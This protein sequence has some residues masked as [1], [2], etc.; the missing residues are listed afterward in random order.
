M[1][2]TSRRCH[3][4]NDCS[5]WF[6]VRFISHEQMYIIGNQLA[7]RIINFRSVGGGGDISSD[8]YFL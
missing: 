2:V 6:T 7:L 4:Q 3:I 5:P 8:G 1:C